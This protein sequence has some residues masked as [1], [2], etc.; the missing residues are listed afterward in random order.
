MDIQP[1]ERL[2]LEFHVEIC[3]C[4]KTPAIKVNDKY[5]CRICF[6][7]GAVKSK[8]PERKEEPMREIVNK[9]L[10]PKALIEVIEHYIDRLTLDIREIL[11]IDD[12]ED[13]R[14][15]AYSDEQKAFCFNFA[16]IPPKACDHGWGNLML[17]SALWAVQVSCALEAIRIA[18]QEQY[19]GF[20]KMD[21]EELDRDI[22]L[23]TGQELQDLT[24][25]HAR[26]FMPEQMGEMGI[27]GL[28]LRDALNEQFNSNGAKEDLA[29]WTCGG[30]VN[31]DEFRKFLKPE[32]VEALQ[33]QIKAGKMGAFHE[34]FYFLTIGEYMRLT[35]D[36]SF[37]TEDAAIAHANATAKVAEV[38]N[39]D[40][41]LKPGLAEHAERVI[42]EGSLEPGFAEPDLGAIA[43]NFKDLTNDKE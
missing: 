33:N 28:R 16:R 27:I 24:A 29:A 17:V 13:E 10:A 26:L 14:V 41:D 15:N 9:E 37:L 32:A 12:Y 21:E 22:E 43:D 34:G 5:I 20:E 18:V 42:E 4:G 1:E 36:E 7:R 19:Y 8:E 6:D 40:D 35:C 3:A 31:T 25:K 2:L 30:D 38:C 23:F 39:I 11:F